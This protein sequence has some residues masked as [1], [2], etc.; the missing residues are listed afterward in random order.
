MLVGVGGVVCLGILQEPLEELL[1]CDVIYVPR[2]RTRRGRS[3]LPLLSEPARQ[4]SWANDMFA[5]PAPLGPH[6][7]VPD[8]PALVDGSH[9]LFHPY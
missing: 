8:L 2:N 7:E 3:S 4:S 6:V 1:D 5:D 9:V